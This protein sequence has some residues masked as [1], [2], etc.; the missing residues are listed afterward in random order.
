MAWSGEQARLAPSRGESRLAFADGTEIN[1]LPEKQQL[2]VTRA[3]KRRTHVISTN[4]LFF[5]PDAQ[6][7]ASLAARSHPVI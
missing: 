2:T 7:I 4:G 1:L 5:S 6:H 3:G